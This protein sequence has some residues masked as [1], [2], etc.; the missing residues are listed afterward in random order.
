L[1]FVLIIVLLAVLGGA[2]W[3]MRSRRVKGSR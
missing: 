2:W 1:G 3:T